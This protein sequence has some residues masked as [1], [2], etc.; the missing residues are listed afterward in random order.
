M[1]QITITNRKAIAMIELIFA[2]V[3]IGIALMSVP[4]LIDRAAKSGYTSLQQEAIAVASSHISLILSMTWDEEDTNSSRGGPILRVDTSSD[5]A[6]SLIARDGLVSREYVGVDGPYFA[7]AST[8]LGQDASDYD[9]I[10]DAAGTTMSL[11]DLETTDSETGDVVDIKVSMQTTVNYI[12]DIPSSNDYN[13]SS[14]IVFD[15]D[16][17]LVTPTTNIKGI[18][19]ILTT[20]NIATELNKTIILRAFGCNN[21]R[22]T[23]ATKDL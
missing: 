20:T 3:I 14:S 13:D 2:I 15:F 4:N 12:S 18:N 10:D 7:T 17:T 21:G 8:S 11:R 22:F 5:S 19:T 1:K 9:D 16:P 6:S 23:P